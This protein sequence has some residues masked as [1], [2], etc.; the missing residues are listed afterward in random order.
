[1]YTRAHLFPRR[2]TL[3]PRGLIRYCDSSD[4]QPNQK[5][6]QTRRQR[7]LQLQQMASSSS[8]IGG[9]K[10]SADKDG[11]R[12]RTSV[13]SSA[14]ATTPGLTPRPGNVAPKGPPTPFAVYMKLLI[15][16]IL[17]FALP[18]IVYFTTQPSWGSTWAGGF[19]AISA[20]VVL[21]GYIITAFLEDSQAGSDTINSKTK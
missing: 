20:N 21:I 10:S 2:S 6:L 19:A 15:F 13:K 9:E 12:Q 16:S 1:M 8:Q 3:G 18:L 5:N 7:S 4:T 14:K 17:M 11:L